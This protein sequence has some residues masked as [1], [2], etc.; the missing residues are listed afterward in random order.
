M[1]RSKWMLYGATG[2]TGTLIAEEAVRRGHRPILAGRN[3]ERLAQLGER[4]SLPWVDV[5]LDDKARLERA[6][7]EVGAVLN[8]AGPFGATVR[9]LVQACLAAGT[10]Y[11]DIAGEIPALQEVFSHDLAAKRRNVA[12]VA[13]VGFGVTVGNSIAAHVAA[14]VANPTTL[15]LAVKASNRLESAGAAKSVLSA[16]AGGGFAYRNGRLVPAKLGKGLKTLAFP[17]G[18]SSILP[19]P[20]A[21]LEAAFHATGIVNITAYAPFKPVAALFLPLIQWGISFPPIRHGIEAAID[22]RQAP[23]ASEAALVHVSYAWARASN[24]QGDEAEAW[25]ELGEGYAFTSASS[26]RAVERVLN[27]DFSGSLTPA[28]AF[29]ADFVLGIEGVRRWSKAPLAVA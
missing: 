7:S 6:V 16:I 26:V 10:H 21:D 29:G 2:V 9:P 15:E 25:L 3:A 23:K 1:L 13:G 11:L 12:L 22:R 19:V 14:Q 17:D 24:E 28:Q 27:G 8:A 5:G 18:E 4:L 20:S